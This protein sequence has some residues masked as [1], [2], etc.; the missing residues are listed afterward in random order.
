M[1]KHFIM[2]L[3]HWMLSLTPTITKGMKAKEVANQEFIFGVI[4]I[5]IVVAIAY[6]LIKSFVMFWII[7]PRDPE[8]YNQYRADKRAKMI[9]NSVNMSSQSISSSIDQQSL[10]NDLNNSINRDF[11]SGNMSRFDG[12][13][14][15]GGSNYNDPNNFY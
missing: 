15:F 4:L 7:R 14:D 12:G 9:S 13:N 5:L 3:G 8:L 11:M 1:L 2:S 10:N 6:S